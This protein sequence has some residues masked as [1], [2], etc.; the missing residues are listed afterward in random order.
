MAPRQPVKSKHEMDA[1]RL[2]NM[3]Q[4]QQEIKMV[5]ARPENTASIAIGK[6]TGD[7][8]YTDDQFYAMYKAKG[9]I[10]TREEFLNN[11]RRPHPVYLKK[12]WYVEMFAPYNLPDLIAASAWAPGEAGGLMLLGNAAFKG[13]GIKTAGQLAALDAS[14]YAALGLDRAAQDAL[15]GERVAAMEA[16][17]EAENAFWA[18]LQKT[19][20][21]TRQYE[22]TMAKVAEEATVEA[23]TAAEEIA[24]ILADESKSFEEKEA[25]LLEGLKNT[26]SNKAAKQYQDALDSTRK[27]KFQADTKAEVKAAQAEAKKAQEE[28]IQTTTEVPDEGGVQMQ[29]SKKV[30]AGADP[31]KVQAGG[32]EPSVR[33]GEGGMTDSEAK[34]AV[35]NYLKKLEEAQAKAEAEESKSAFH[36]IGPEPG[37]ATEPVTVSFNFKGGAPA[38]G[39][40]ASAK[41]G[42]AVATEGAGTAAR[43][44][45]DELLGSA[46][47]TVDAADYEFGEAIREV[48][49]QMARVEKQGGAKGVLEDNPFISQAHEFANQ[50]YKA[51]GE[52]KDIGKFLYR[53]DLSTPETAVW[54]NAEDGVAHVSYRGTANLTDVGSDVSL[55]VGRE[56]L[57][58]AGRFARSVDETRRAYMVLSRNGMD[59]VTVEGSGHSLGGAI[60][61]HVAEEIGHVPWYGRQVTFNAGSSP[62]GKSAL[63]HHLTKFLRNT[64]KSQK[65]DG[66]ITN[67]RNA[68]DP[69]SLMP[70]RYGSHV[71]VYTGTVNPI[72]AHRLNSFL[73]A[74]VRV[75]SIGTQGHLLVKDGGLMNRLGMTFGPQYLNHMFQTNDDGSLKT[76]ANGYALMAEQKEGG[77]DPTTIVHFGEHTEVTSD[78]TT[79]THTGQQGPDDPVIT[80]TTETT[81][82]DEVTEDTTVVEQADG[83]VDITVDATI[84]PVE[85]KTTEMFS[86]KEELNYQNFDVLLETAVKLC[87]AVD[88]DDADFEEGQYILRRDV[89]GKRMKHF[90]LFSQNEGELSIAFSGM[91]EVVEDMINEADGNLV[92]HY[93]N[94]KAILK[95][96]NTKMGFHAACLAALNTAYPIIR[97]ELDKFALEYATFNIYGASSGGSM[98]TIFY[99]LYIHDDVRREMKME[100]KE[101]ITLGAPRTVVDDFHNE[102][103]YNEKCPNLLRVWN[104][105]DVE[106]YRPFKDDV[107]DNVM[108]VPSNFVHVGKPFC[109]DSNYETQNANLLIVSQLQPS[110]TLIAGLL[111]TFDMDQQLA[112][113]QVLLSSGWQSLLAQC[114]VH[115]L[116]RAEP[117]PEIPMLAFSE[118]CSE[119][120]SDMMQAPSLQTRVSYLKGFTFEQLDQSSYLKELD[121]TSQSF[122]LA[123]LALVSMAAVRRQTVMGT[124][125][126]YGAYIDSL[127]LREVKEKKPITT[128][129]AP[130]EVQQMKEWTEYGVP[131]VPVPS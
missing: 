106:T 72:A 33:P 88:D 60:V 107:I 51:V 10:H 111:K 71:T 79:E 42:V 56:E 75:R 77:T 4:L 64:E 55:A 30:T 50:S 14:R 93:S 44:A 15:Y 96:P 31:K 124:V 37:E 114:C 1:E 122:A 91:D 78:G 83:K 101:V 32:A 100:V 25:E 76:D 82:T 2:E 47:N 120:M 40:A 67:V 13:L 23:E 29:P 86:I 73:S 70:V 11:T 128:R 52:R 59:A 66:L 18:N 115:I 130:K 19:Y 6:Q 69:V 74:G 27:A 35:D 99:W 95:N 84:V 57:D 48:E 46:V 9:G 54:F 39:A 34:A 97:A 3:Y 8:G 22:A 41:E 108:E 49:R 102:D 62:Y 17:G 119:W 68:A 53:E 7:Q 21:A 117:N 129:V 126:G 26:K 90:V 110:N 116:G 16:G 98:A 58:P 87:K 131:L 24:T 38:P 113:M 81:T 125:E 63:E 94:L 109:V 43:E 92:R 12:P 80:D 5:L 104:T 65:L 103:D 118:L 61:Q 123:S 89:F 45:A 20:D 105:L 28:A 127:V 36:F 121:G 85:E 112:L